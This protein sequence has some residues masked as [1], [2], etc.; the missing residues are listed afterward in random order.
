MVNDK[1]TVYDTSSV[2]DEAGGGGGSIIPD[3]Y[4]IYQR[5]EMNNNYFPQ[6]EQHLGKIIVDYTD[7]LQLVTDEKPSNP[8]PNPLLYP[9]FL[10]AQATNG[11]SRY[12]SAGFS[13]WKSPLEYYYYDDH[14][15]FGGPFSYPSKNIIVNTKST[16][17][18]LIINGVTLNTT[19]EI[20]DHFSLLILGSGVSSNWSFYSFKV[21]DETETELKQ[22]WLPALEIS[23]NKKGILDIKNGLFVQV[24]NNSNASLYSEITL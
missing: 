11:Y 10:R 3:G 15:Q 18:K 12:I 13:C 4:K 21:Y 8:D 22:Y 16:K 1:P 20:A 2:Y 7:V 24:Y 19:R 23:T 9:L 14:T 5:L 6:D 17:N